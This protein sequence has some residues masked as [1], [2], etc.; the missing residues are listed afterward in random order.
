MN[1]D[2]LAAWAEATSLT[3]IEEA[4]SARATAVYDLR[5]RWLRKAVTAWLTHAGDLDAVPEDLASL[6]AT[7]T[8]GFERDLLDRASATTDLIEETLREGARLGLIETRRAF[9]EV[10]PVEVTA[11]DLVA[12]SR[13]AQ[14]GLADA[15][16]FP[17]RA[18]ADLRRRLRAVATFADL[19]AALTA[20]VSKTQANARASVSWALH[21]GFNEG[22]DAVI[23]GNGAQ[24]MWVAER[25][26][27]LACLAYSGEVVSDTFPEGLT[28]GTKGLGVY[29]SLTGPPLHPH[30]RC[31]L[32]PW[33]DEWRT[34]G[35]RHDAPE[36][37]ER[38]AMRSVLKGWSGFASNQEKLRAAQTLLSDDLALPKSVKTVARNSL[39]RGAFPTPPEAV[40]P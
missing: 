20:A 40:Q 34:P 4:V 25:T 26:A 22:G 12:E 31:R 32:A 39:K 3:D 30:C 16:R 1:H 24:K 8:P 7:L 27:C 5:Q 15:R 19:D 9:P 2:D 11:R 14:K 6:L 33:K 38:E 18:A 10:A 28:F 13:T 23:V 29:G 21:R 36:A 37:L 17:E 35:L